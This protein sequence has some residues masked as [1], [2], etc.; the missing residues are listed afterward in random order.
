MEIKEKLKEAYKVIRYHMMGKKLR[1]NL[2]DTK[3]KYLSYLEKIETEQSEGYIGADG[4]MKLIMIWDFSKK[5]LSR[6]D[7]QR[8]INALKLISYR[9]RDEKWIQT[10]I[11]KQIRE[12]DNLSKKYFGERLA[13]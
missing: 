11:N 10:D 12:A 6:Q 1:D 9:R 3:E 7:Y 2:E 13:W 5:I 8:G 4:L